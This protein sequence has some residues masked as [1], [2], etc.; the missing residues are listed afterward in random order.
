MLFPPLCVVPAFLKVKAYKEKSCTP[1]LAS[2]LPIF[3]QAFAIGKKLQSGLLHPKRAPVT[4][5]LCLKPLRCLL[6]THDI[7]ESL[8]TQ[9]AK[10][11][12]V[13]RQ[14]YLKFLS[15]LRFLARQGLPLRGDG[16]E[17]DSYFTQSSVEKT[18]LEYLTG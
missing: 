5:R 7:G 11:K 18:T 6:T 17:S 3:P 8:S 10:E 15:N 13:R 4:K 12:V 1:P 14:C 2:R 16:D 9:H